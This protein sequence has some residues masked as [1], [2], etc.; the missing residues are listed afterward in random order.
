MN[1]ISKTLVAV[2]VVSIP[3]GALASALLDRLM[4]YRDYY[5]EST[6]A[7]CLSSKLAVQALS[8]PMCA[9]RPETLAIVER[10][11]NSGVDEVLQLDDVS[12]ALRDLLANG[13]PVDEVVDLL[14]PFVR[15]QLPELIRSSHCH[16]DNGGEIQIHFEGDNDGS[17]I[18][19]YDQN[20]QLNVSC[21]STRR[22]RVVLLDL[23]EGRM[24]GQFHPQSSVD[25]QMIEGLTS[26][27]AVVSL[28]S[29]GA[30]LSERVF[31]NFGSQQPIPVL[32]RLHAVDD[33]SR[34]PKGSG[35]LVGLPAGSRL[36]LYEMN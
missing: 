5:A 22:F 3:A 27:P 12:A 15:Q 29:E 17:S 36:V 19:P 23:T 25:V 24:P 33:V 10:L 16:F 9:L 31:E 11:R 8:D 21:D 30:L 6:N 32:A 18:A 26:Y 14:P 2:I 7:D 35:R 20:L 1:I 34:A 28:L 13:V 4:P